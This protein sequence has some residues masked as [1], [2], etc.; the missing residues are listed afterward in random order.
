MKPGPAVLRA[1]SA[2]LSALAAAPA[3]AQPARVP[4]WLLLDLSGES[5]V[6]AESAKAVVR[7][8]VPAKVWKL[9]PQ[10]KW[11]CLGQVE[12]GLTREGTCVVTP[13]VVPLPRTGTVRAV[14]WRPEKAASTFD[15]WPGATADPCQA[16]ARDGLK[17][18]A[19]AV[20]SALVKT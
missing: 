8:D 4:K 19:G 10:G 6:D 15:A 2:L 13:R 1:G 12:G 3:S 14:P 20:A 16:L 18:A 17:E 11:T 9:D 5:L 7:E